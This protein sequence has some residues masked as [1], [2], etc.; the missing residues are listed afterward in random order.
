MTRNK[1]S[2]A[3]LGLVLVAALAG[4]RVYQARHPRVE[5]LARAGYVGK[6]DTWADHAKLLGRP[7][8]PLDLTDWRGQPVT[9]D[10]MRGRIV[11]VDFWATWCEPCLAAVPHNNAVAQKYRD[12][13]VLLVGACGGGEEDKMK[14]VA[15]EVKMEY[16][17]GK[18]S[19]QTTTAWGVQWW[20]HYAIVDRR[21]NVRALGIDGDYVERIVDALLKE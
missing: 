14:A 15:D 7:A 16:P 8:P 18:A 1:L 20:P 3:L 17:T 5:Q 11:V 2:L 21:G 4:W 6:D 9:P 12:K 13:G 10:A 19:E